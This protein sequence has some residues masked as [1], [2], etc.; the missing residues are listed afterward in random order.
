VRRIKRRFLAFITPKSGLCI[1]RK[2]GSIIQENNAAN[3]FIAAIKEAGLRR[4]RSLGIYS[5][6]INIVST[7]KDKKY[8]SAHHEVEPGIYVLTHSS[9]LEKKD[10]LEK[11]SS[12]LKM[13]W[14]VDIVK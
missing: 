8:A 3:T 10:R 9:T 2:D 14:R 1:Y 12:A 6:G 7:T 5:R 11:I 4:V 13:G